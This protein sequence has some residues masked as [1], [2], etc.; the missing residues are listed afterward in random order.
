MKAKP[1]PGRGTTTASLLG[2]LADSIEPD[3]GLDAAPEHDAAAES[4]VRHLSTKVAEDD[5]EAVVSF[6]SDALDLAKAKMH[7]AAKTCA[8]ADE[9]CE[10]SYWLG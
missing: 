10:P 4:I 1:A 7:D 2:R 5:L 3:R 8:P 9:P 6:L